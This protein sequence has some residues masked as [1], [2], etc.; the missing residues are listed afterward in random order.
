MSSLPIRFAALGFLLAIPTLA[1]GDT[2]IAGGNLINQTWTLAGSPYIV[3]GRDHSLGGFPHHPVRGRGEVHEHGQPDL[4]EGSRAEVAIFNAAGRHVRTLSATVAG[5][6]G[7]IIEW[8]GR[9][10]GGAPVGSGVFFY[11]VRVDGRFVG[12]N[13]A[14][15]TR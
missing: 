8:D 4:G 5:D 15:M 10:A 12:S 3:Q 6:R 2:I 1:A 14:V 7:G 13:R 11:E 9:D